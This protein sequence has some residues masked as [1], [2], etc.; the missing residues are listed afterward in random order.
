MNAQEARSIVASRVSD[1]VD[2][3]N[4]ALSGRNLGAIRPI[5][6]RIDSSGDEPYWFAE[7]RGRNKLPNLDGKTVGSVIE[8]LT[9]CAMER[10]LLDGGIQLS[11]NPAK[12]I[13]VPELDLGIKSPSTNFCT[14]EP[15]FSAYDRLLGNESDALILLTNY[16]SAK[17]DRRRFN[18]RIIDARSLRGSEIADQ[19]L[20]AVARNVRSAFSSDPATLQTLWRFVAYVNQ[21]EWETSALLKLL[22]GEFSDEDIGAA[23]DGVLAEGERKNKRERNAEHQIPSEV[24]ARLTDIKKTLPLREGLVRAVDKWVVSSLSDSA[25]YPSPNEF[26]RLMESPLDGKIGM[27]FALQW[28]Y[29]FA[30]VFPQHRKGE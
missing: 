17:K 18:L 16:Q 5:L 20:C 27:S 6:R 7:L 10:F 29:N 21:G 3:V 12:G 24:F 9:V 19:K 4:N 23:I 13:D 8:K 2:A 14:S 25:R 1:L 11:V 15:F 30:S 28:R 26:R 22:E